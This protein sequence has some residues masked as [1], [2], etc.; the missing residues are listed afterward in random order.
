[1]L[2]GASW[3]RAVAEPRGSAAGRARRRRRDDELGGREAS[4][5][6]KEDRRRVPWRGGGLD[7]A[8]V[9]GAEENGARRR[10]KSDAGFTSSEKTEEGQ[11]S[12][13]L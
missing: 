13:V 3:R 5:E 2:T 12:E 7:G 6:L 9:E 8:V 10:G 11:I 4:V 1:M